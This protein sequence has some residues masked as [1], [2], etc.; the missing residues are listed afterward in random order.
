M[1]IYS[2]SRSLQVLGLLAGANP[3]KVAARLS[4][5][6]LLLVVLLGAGTSV[7]SSMDAVADATAALVRALIIGDVAARSM[8]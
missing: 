6:D 8:L 5:A 2:R 7:S 1:W 4:L 3:S